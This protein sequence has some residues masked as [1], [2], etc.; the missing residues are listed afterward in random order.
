MFCTKMVCD[1]LQEVLTKYDLLDKPWLVYNTD[2]SGAN[3]ETDPMKVI[4]P[5]NTKVPVPAIVS[6]RSATTT[7][8]SSISAAG[9][10]MPP[11][12]VFKGKRDVS[13]LIF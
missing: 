12:F 2:E 8:I 6:T 13:T 4:G 9:Q 7:I 11:F 1:M 10:V 3:T 5:N